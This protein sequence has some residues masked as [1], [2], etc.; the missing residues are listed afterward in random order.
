[1]PSPQ[2][3]PDTRRRG[4]DAPGDP[5]APYDAERTRRWSHVLAIAVT[6]LAMLGGLVAIPVVRAVFPAVLNSVAPV[7]IRA[8]V[9]PPT[10]APASPPQKTTACTHKCIQAGPSHRHICS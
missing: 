1:M 3:N 5:L 9:R 8:V 4:S 6:C 7:M 2:T 10:A